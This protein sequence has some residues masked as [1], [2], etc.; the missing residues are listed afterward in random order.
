MFAVVM[1]DPPH[2]VSFKCAPET[3]AEL[4]ERD[5][6][7][8]APYLARA[9]WVS[10]EAAGEAMDDT[11]LGARLADAYDLVRAKLPRKV[12]EALSR[13]SRD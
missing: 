6:I 4:V 5:G 10:V 7:I 3:F 13:R 11:E 12:Q 8:P 2:R 1:L 9:H